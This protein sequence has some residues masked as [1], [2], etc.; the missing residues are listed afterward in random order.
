MAGT[1]IQPVVVT[2]D[3]PVNVLGTLKTLATFG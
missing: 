3:V 2:Q 1:G